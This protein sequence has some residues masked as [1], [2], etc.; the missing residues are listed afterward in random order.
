MVK[1][2]PSNEHKQFHDG[3]EK[4]NDKTNHADENRELFVTKGASAR[5]HAHTAVSRMVV[6]KSARDNPERYCGWF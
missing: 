3:R 1:G 5:T 2:Q 6:G 4:K